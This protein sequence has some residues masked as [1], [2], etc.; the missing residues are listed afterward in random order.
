[1]REVERENKRNKG[2]FTLRELLQSLFIALILVVII[3]TFIMQLFWIPSRSMEPVL[4]INDRI[5]VTKFSY[6]YR[7]PQRGDIIVFRFPKDTTKH[8]VKRV[9]G[10]GGEIISI[11]HNQVYING[12]LLDE[13]YINNGKYQDFG[14]IVVPENHYF[15]LGDNRDSSEDSRAFGCV[16]SQLVVGKA[17]FRYWPLARLGKIY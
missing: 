4:L 10:M 12:K 6:W 11:R 8:L 7:E 14:P 5:V 13:P 15:V 17:Q 9:I 3:K 2:T 1:M 16:P